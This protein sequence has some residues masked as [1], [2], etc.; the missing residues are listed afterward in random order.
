VKQP[1]AH[2]IKMVVWVVSAENFLTFQATER[3]DFLL[4]AVV[5]GHPVDIAVVRPQVE[6]VLVVHMVALEL[7]VPQILA[8]VAAVVAVML[9]QVEVVVPGLSL[10]GFSLQ[11]I[12]VQLRD[13]Q[14]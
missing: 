12:Q 10:F 5:V 4:E 7:P 14:R 13:H 2:T 9:E 3:V 1:E 6:Q 11:S 8:A